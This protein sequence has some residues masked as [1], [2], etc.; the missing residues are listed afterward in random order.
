M[1]I[2]GYVASDGDILKTETNMIGQKMV[3]DR[4]SREEAIKTLAGEELD[5]A[6]ENVGENRRSHS[7]KVTAHRK[8]V[9]LVHLKNGRP[10]ETASQWRHT[11]SRKD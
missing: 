5:L 9:Y 3:V 1:S 6:V 11:N 8:S 7:S 10:F 4:V 2:Y